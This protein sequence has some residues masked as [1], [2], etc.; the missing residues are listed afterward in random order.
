M[1][2]TAFTVCSLF[3]AQWVCGQERWL[4]GAGL[5]YCSYIDNP[6]VNLSV[7][8]RIAERFFVGPDF[9]ALLT[10]EREANG[11][12]KKRKEVEYNFNAHQLFELNE[13][14]NVYPLAGI[15]VSKVT[16]HS[17]METPQTKW[18]SGVN[19]GGG[20]EFKIKSVMLVL[21]SKYVLGFEKFDV[22]TGLLFVL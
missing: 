10:R 2:K 17:A 6:G 20:M 4:L 21:E 13:L 7:T 15:N 5:T 19:I 14:L 9:S 22:T 8:Y 3:L 12:L 11:V 16:N 18:I 1:L